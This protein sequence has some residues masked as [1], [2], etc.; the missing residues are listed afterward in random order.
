VR[1]RPAAQ[2]EVGTFL[3]DTADGLRFV[4]TTSRLRSL[5]L[6]AVVGSVSSTATEGLAVSVAHELHHG[7][8][9]V[10]FLTATSPFGFVLGSYAVLR[11]PA[12]ARERLLPA[13][14]VLSAAPLLL[15]PLVPGLGPVLV[16]WVLAGAGATVNLIAGP[17]F[18]QACPADYRGR[19]YGVASATLMSA[20]GAGLLLAGYLATLTSGRSAV[21]LVAAIMLVLA[22]PLLRAQGN[23]QTVRETNK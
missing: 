17:A 13:L 16:V 8:V 1:Q 19:A 12:P 11:I 21:A 23:R 4:L 6:C 9:A 20:Q 5:L 22:V 14:L 7:S 15:T 10:G 18:V 2:T 3:R